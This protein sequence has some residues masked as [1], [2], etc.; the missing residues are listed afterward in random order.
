MALEEQAIDPTANPEEP[1]VINNQQLVIVMRYCFGGQ[2]DWLIRFEEK[3]QLL[4]TV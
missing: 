2:T 1:S 3:S 4:V